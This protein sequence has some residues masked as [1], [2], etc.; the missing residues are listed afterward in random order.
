DPAGTWKVIVQELLNNSEDEATYSYTPPRRVR[1]IAGATPRAVF[2]AEDRDNVFRFARTQHDVTI[3]KGTSAFNDA[4]A[5][6]LIKILE[7][8]G[9]R[10]KVM[11][12][13]AASKPRN[14][15]EEEARTWVGLNYAGKG[16]IKAGAANAPV[17]AGFAVQGPVILL[18][19]PD[20]H[21]IIKTLQAEK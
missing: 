7:P 11:E 20:D 13:A 4:A 9:V 1:A 10:C 16:Q 21:P 2:F 14:L 17:Q 3:V 15:T 19:N 8:W 18:G 5:K 6:R 12:L